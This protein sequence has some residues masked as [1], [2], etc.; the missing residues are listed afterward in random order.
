MTAP[1][2]FFRRTGPSAFEPTEHAS[3]AWS[4][5]DHHFAPVAGLMVHMIECFRA[6]HAGAD[7][8][9]G[10]ISFDILGRIP[11]QELE[12]DVEVLRPGR[13]IELMQATLSI[14]GRA[15]ITARAWYL[16]H[17]DTAD[18]AAVESEPIPSPDECPEW[19]MG[20]GW[21]GG[22]IAQLQARVAQRRPGRG[23][24]W[25]CSPTQLVEGEQ[26]SQLARFCT[27]I[28]GA[29]GI[30]ARQEPG[31]WAFPNVDLTVHLH[32]LP[33]GSWTGL[34]TA[35]TW[36]AD[37]VGLT[38]STLHD[39]TGPVGRAEQILTLRRL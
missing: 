2:A 10:R 33:T 17:A 24:V 26:I 35:V 27:N 18:V 32:R 36:G 30:A 23:T 25:L 22:Y 16:S 37:G 31:T 15:V 5:E 4:E 20:Q 34:D 38:S 21:P 1:Q 39:E 7:L 12:I 29:N 28:D 6:E 14:G 3:G 9:L 8:Q 11:M 19:N 13:T